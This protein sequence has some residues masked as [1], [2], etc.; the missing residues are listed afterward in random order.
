MA[1]RAGSSCGAPAAEAFAIADVSDDARAARPAAPAAVRSRD[2]VA[3]A[4][5]FAMV[6]AS[7]TP[8][9][10]DLPCASPSAVVFADAVWSAVALKSR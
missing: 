10:A 3:S 8:I 7:D 1:P 2:S 4:R 6:S 9:A 5:W